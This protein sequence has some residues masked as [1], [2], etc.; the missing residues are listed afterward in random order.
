[1]SRR[2]S[3][4]FL[5]RT[6][7][8]DPSVFISVETS[9]LCNKWV[10]RGFTHPLSPFLLSRRGSLDPQVKSL[11]KPWPSPQVSSPFLTISWT[12]PR[13]LPDSVSGLWV[14]HSPLLRFLDPL[15]SRSLIL[16]WACVWVSPPGYTIVHTTTSYVTWF[17]PLSGF[18]HFWCLDTQVPGSHDSPIADGS[19]PLTCQ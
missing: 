11:M 6:S 18:R 19:W 3:V 5:K 8:R 9:I 10:T 17:E 16:W 7:T 12:S 14:S 15:N 4:A 2:I 13:P 1:V